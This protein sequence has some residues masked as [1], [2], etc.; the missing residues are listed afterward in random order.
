M[1]SIANDF[2][3]NSSTIQLPVFDVSDISLEN[4]KRLVDASI[5][6]GFLYI[7]PKGTP[8]SESLVDSQFDLSKQFFATPFDEKKT[9]YVGKTNTNRGWL[10]MHNEILD[11]AHNS[12]E[13]KE[14][15]NIGEFIDGKPQQ[16]M[17]PVLSNDSAMNQLIMFEDACKKTCD[18]VLDLLGLGLEIEDG[19]NWFSK[20]HGQPSGCTMRML[21]YPALP[22]VSQSD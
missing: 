22:E 16:E 3:T 6:Y 20:R 17:P 12:K 8:F 13:F 5:D 18:Q 4:A 7:S 2:T 1:G 19:N 11:P 14:G 15:F 21:F 9:Y 10:G